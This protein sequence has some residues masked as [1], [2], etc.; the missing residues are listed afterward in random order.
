MELIDIRKVL[1]KKSPKHAAR[2]PR[3]VTNWLARLIHQRELNEL[4]IYGDGLKNVEFIT[5]VLNK[6]EIK[7]KV[8][9][10]DNISRAN[11]P[12]FASNH[13]P[14]GIDGLIL[15]EQLNLNAGNTRAVVNDLLMNVEPIRDLFVPVNKHGMQNG[16]Y[17]TRINQM[18]ESQDNILYF[19]AGLCSR[20]I[21]GKIQ[22]IEW[23]KSFVQKA[24]ETQRDII[25]IYITGQ[26]S[27]K[28]YRLAKWRK[29]LG[30]KFNIEM[31]L[32]PSEMLRQ[33]GKQICIII[34]EPIKHRQLKE[35]HN[36]Q[37]WSQI[38]RQNCYE[39]KKNQ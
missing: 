9:G 39:L 18:Y 12:I 6:L 11:R 33:K 13:P 14:G 21:D 38:V 4:L 1:E 5:A 35:D 3:F 8:Y 20:L 32:L 23:K 17:V 10:A 2:I 24:I 16:N 30:I 37:K 28:F 25:P 26:N 36:S 27:M 7:R 29:C 15:L 31:L 34:G 22:D 19:P